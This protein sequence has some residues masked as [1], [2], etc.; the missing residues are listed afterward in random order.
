MLCLRL[1]RLGLLRLRLLRLGLFGLGLFCLRLFRLRL[2]LLGLSL[3]LDLLRG[4]LGLPGGLFSFGGFAGLLRFGGLA[5]FLSLGCFTRLLRLRCLAGLLGFGSFPGLLGFS[6]LAGL[7]GLG[8]GIVH[9]LDGGRLTLRRRRGLALR[10]RQRAVQ[11][12]AKCQEIDQLF[13]RSVFL[14]R[15]T[16]DRAVFPFNTF[17][18]HSKSRK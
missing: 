5:G 8:F 15:D 7:L 10:H 16:H 11:A 17:I 3:G 1:F 13:H 2:L 4:F 18:R 9:G 12:Q 14:S 6:G